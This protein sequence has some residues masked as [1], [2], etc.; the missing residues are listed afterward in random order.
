[1]PTLDWLNRKSAVTAA[2]RAIDACQNVRY[3]VTQSC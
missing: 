2:A 1:M 3:W